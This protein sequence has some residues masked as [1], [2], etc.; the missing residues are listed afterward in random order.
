LKDP[1]SEFHRSLTLWFVSTS[2]HI[3]SS[4]Q[5][6]FRSSTKKPLSLLP[7][8]SLV[9]LVALSLF[10]LQRTNEMKGNPILIYFLLVYY[11]LGIRLFLL[12]GI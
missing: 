7:P 5:I 3:T 8:C 6:P 11:S 1:I 10:L 2:P 9:L 4:N 12:L